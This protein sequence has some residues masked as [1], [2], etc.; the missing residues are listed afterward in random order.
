MLI[1]L[2]KYFNSHP[3]I[4]IDWLVKQIDKYEYISFDIFDTLIK[5]KCGDAEFLFDIVAASYN[6]KHNGRLDT[7]SFRK[8]RILAEVKARQEA[9]IDGH[10]EITLE[11]IYENIVCIS[12]NIEKKK[13]LQIEIEK[14]LDLTQPNPQIID[15]Y[16]YCIKQG[17]RIALISDM[18]LNEDVVRSIL[19]KSGIDGYQSLYLSS[20]YDKQKITGDLFDMYLQEGDKTKN[21]L[22][23]GDSI[24]ADYLAAKR[25]G[26]HAIHI[27][28]N[29]R[30]T[31]FY[32]TLTMS[33]NEK[34]EWM[35][36]EQIQNNNIDPNWS[37]YY[38]FGYECLGPFVYAVCSWLVKDIKKR[39]INQVFFLSRD[40]YIIKKVFDIMSRGEIATTYL[41]VSRK[42]VIIP[43]M[44]KTPDINSFAKFSTSRVLWSYKNFADQLGIDEKVALNAWIDAGLSINEHFYNHE[45]TNNERIKKFYELI[46]DDFLKKSKEQYNLIVAYLKQNKVQ[47]KIAIFDMGW[48]GTIQKCLNDILLSANC[49]TEIHGYYLGLK[50]GALKGTEA[51]TFYNMGVV[52][53]I[54]CAMMFD[55]F[56]T[57][58]EGSTKE[59]T[60]EKCGNIIPILN[61]CE[62]G[63]CKE[64]KIIDDIFKGVIRFANDIESCKGI[65][66]PNREYADR[67]LLLACRYPRFKELKMF[68]NV[69][70]Y[71]KAIYKMAIPSSALQYLKSP[72]LLKKEFWESGWK[73]GF[74]KNL[75]KLPFPYYRLYSIMLRICG[76]G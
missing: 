72:S 67:K 49:N 44:W 2:K 36:L 61:D 21:R 16:Q 10:Q 41:H 68:S 22:H 58:P 39:G 53:N 26:I 57:A 69:T 35:C 17:K 76:G 65:K 37:D 13:L 8:A 28:R 64:L 54:A 29:P 25:K 34:H 45:I 33:Q 18:Y 3:S 12:E 66:L 27:P 60:K 19:Y 71:D 51:K 48:R 70:F 47:G 63:K 52:P 56:F 74:M 62:Y 43:R 50:N 9:V 55:F 15:I 5:R 32:R 46:S 14:E 40:G 4:D 59:Y 7:V 73:I 38:C 20:S 31:R 23:I 11:Q 42:A 24:K 75:V 30:R 6:E 1:L